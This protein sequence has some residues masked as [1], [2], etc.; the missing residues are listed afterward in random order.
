M[1]LLYLIHLIY[2]IYLLQNM[3]KTKII[4]TIG[5]AC[6]NKSMLKKMV[7]A[8]MNVARLNF[9]HNTHAYH[10]G[11][12]KLIRNVERDTKKTITIIQDLQGP[13]IRLGKIEPRTLKKNQ[14]VVFSTES[15][16]S[17]NKIPVTYKKLHEDVKKGQR[18]FIADGTI[19]LEI[20]KVYKNDV[21]CRVKIGGDISSNKGMNLP[22]SEISLD[23]LTLKDK[24][25]LEIGIKEQV[26]FVAL[27]FVRSAKEVLNLKKLIKKLNKKYKI[28]NLEGPKVI[29]KIERPE[30]VKDFDEILK[31]T[32]AVM[33]ARGDLGIELSP[34]E[35]P[36]V[37]K[38]FIGK[39]LEAAKPVIVA[40]QMLESMT[41]SP[42]PTRAEASDVANAVI[43]H[44]DA[45][46][47]SGETAS[48][49]FPLKAVQIMRDIIKNTEESI[50]DDYI[51][52]EK[53]NNIDSED[54]TIS[55]IANT[56]AT[57]VKA[58]LILTATISGYTGRIVSRYRPELRVYAACVDKRIQHQLNLTW[59]MQPFVISKCKNLP[60]IVKKSLQKLKREKILKKGD[61]VI[62]IMGKPMRKKR[63]ASFVEVLE[64]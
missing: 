61:R 54:K 2:L 55:Q 49:K 21:Y 38:N 57:Q 41:K 56:L 46:M 42:I 63:S 30:A 28:K 60:E 13:R 29:V 14:K 53:V 35:V 31:V 24:K 45:V 10:K 50:Y 18:I 8:G 6:D 58:K 39:C 3:K 20:E 64:I 27:S 19:L 32:D 43:D 59:G 47:L 52:Q 23:T 4:C 17:Q 48:G 7:N 5:P 15:T 26:D 62:V 51:V 11:L 16:K 9:S 36:V 25:D 44:T 34:E 40:T 1:D 22:D 33:I 37:Q 12:I